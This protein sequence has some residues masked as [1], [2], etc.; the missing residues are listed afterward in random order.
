M[1]MRARK[2]EREG[3]IHSVLGKLIESKSS[4]ANLPGTPNRFPFVPSTYLPVTMLV[5]SYHVRT[6]IERNFF[7]F[8]LR[9]QTSTSYVCANALNGR[10]NGLTARRDCVDDAGFFLSVGF[11][12]PGDMREVWQ[13]DFRNDNTSERVVLNRVRELEIFGENLSFSA[14]WKLPHFAHF[15]FVYRY[16]GIH[17]E[18]A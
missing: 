9:I 16:S 1:S 8:F 7:D 14:E 4:R 13:N 3:E 18:Y 10:E 15:A 6:F 2:G 17:V 11:H 5:S 12:V